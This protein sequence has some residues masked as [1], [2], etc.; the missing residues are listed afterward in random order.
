MWLQERRKREMRS[1]SCVIEEDIRKRVVGKSDL[2]ASSP[3]AQPTFVLLY[4]AATVSFMF[5]CK[6]YRKP[7]VG[8]RYEIERNL[9]FLSRKIAVENVTKL[10]SEKIHRLI[11]LSKYKM[12]KKL[13]GGRK[14]ERVIIMMKM[15]VT[16]KLPEKEMCLFPEENRLLPKTGRELIRS[17]GE[18]N[19]VTGRNIQKLLKILKLAK[20]R[21]QPLRKVRGLM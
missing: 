11:K 3:F 10:T 13:L 5:R 19:A 2:L 7:F 1:I 20:K 21:N 14:S 4:K 18:N 16:L 9:P 17:H 8:L 15:T 6:Y 12:S